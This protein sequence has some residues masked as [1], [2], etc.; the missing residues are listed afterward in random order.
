MWNEMWEGRERAI[1]EK[2]EIRERIFERIYTKIER[3]WNLREKLKE[4]WE[5]LKKWEKSRQKWEKLNWNR[6]NWIPKLKFD[7]DSSKQDKEKKTKMKIF[8]LNFKPN[9]FKILRNSCHL[10]SKSKFHS[11]VHCRLNAQTHSV[12]QFFFVLEI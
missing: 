9:S 3:I 6:E 4:N 5:N 11:F 2:L 1:F 12:I 7:W 10:L 8:N